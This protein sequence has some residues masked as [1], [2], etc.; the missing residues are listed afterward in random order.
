MN[1][2]PYFPLRDPARLAK[3]IA[4]GVFAVCIST[5][6]LADPPAG[7]GRNKIHSGQSKD[8]QKGASD[9]P[10]GPSSDDRLSRDL[11][12]AGI[13]VAAASL[14]VDD[15]NI[16]RSNYK[17]LP[18]GIRKNLARGKPLPPGIASQSLPGSYISRLPVH[19]GYEWIGAGTDLLLVEAGSR[20][21]AD[22]LVDVFK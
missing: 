8:Q 11:A 21:I 2:K 10:S 19:A 7:K 14:L 13:T 4:L 6:V 15:L 3:R 22:V 17:P 18:P 1:D 5:A 20:V 16:P 9:R 12:F